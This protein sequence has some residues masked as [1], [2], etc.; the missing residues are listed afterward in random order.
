LELSGGAERDRTLIAP[1]MVALLPD[2]MPHRER[3]GAGGL[4]VLAQARRGDDGG[5][6][7]A[8]PPGRLRPRPA[9]GLLGARLYAEL[10]RG[11]DLS[12]LVV[13]D[14]LRDLLAESRERVLACRVARAAERLEEAYRAPPRVAELALDSGVHPDSFSRSFRKQL[15]CTVPEYVRRVR[16]RRAARL[17]RL[18]ATPLSDVAAA[19]GFADQ[20][21]LTR[22]FRDASGFTPGAYR[23]FARSAA[24]VRADAVPA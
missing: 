19:C 16:L 5:R 9:H 17:L 6:R 21:H 23:R 24:P 4:C 18:S 3:A 1:E 15:G 2:A 7:L 14:L 10:M 13:E 8:S 22:Q 11:D 20:S 12:P